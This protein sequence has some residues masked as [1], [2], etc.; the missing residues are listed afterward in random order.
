M[1]CGV[2]ETDVT[3]SVIRLPA[4]VPD[5]G[6]PALLVNVPVPV[7]SGID[8]LLN[9]IVVGEPFV[10]FT[11][12]PPLYSQSTPPPSGRRRSTELTRPLW[13][14]PAPDWPWATVRTHVPAANVGAWSQ[15]ENA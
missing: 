13:I 14:P 2:G 1:F 10:I 12:R 9:A 3:A 5:G 7:N 8:A 15:F 4:A 6:Q 11:L